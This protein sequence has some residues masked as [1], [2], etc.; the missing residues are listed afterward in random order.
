MPEDLRQAVLGSQ[1]SKKLVD[2]MDNDRERRAMIRTSTAVDVIQGGDKGE[3][4]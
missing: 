1:N 3:L 2:Y 4:H